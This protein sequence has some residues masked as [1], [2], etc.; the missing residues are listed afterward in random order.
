MAGL[1]DIARKAGVRPEYVE[2]VV[3]AIVELIA[4]GNDFVVLRNFGTFRRH[5][6]PAREVISPQLPGGKATVP[7]KTVIKF[8]HSGNTLPILNGQTAVG[9]GTARKL[10]PREDVVLKTRKKAK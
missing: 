10:A 1:K 8:K 6:Q 3:D 2:R 5:H 4:E 9:Q 7:E